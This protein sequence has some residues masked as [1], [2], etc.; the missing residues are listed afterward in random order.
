[1][2]SSTPPVISLQ[3]LP[4]LREKTEDVAQVL[5]QQLASHLE[6]LRPLYAPER[7]FGK[8]TGG[9]LDAPTSELALSG[10]KE[11]YTP[12]AGKPVNL[13]ADFDT[14]WLSLTGTSV[15]LLPW[16]YTHMVGDKEVA[17]TNPAR[18]VL[19][20]KTGFSIGKL[21]AALNGKEVA[22]PEVLRQ[23]IVNALVL[24]SVLRLAPGLTQLL[25]DLRYEVKTE[26]L[27]EFRSVP[28]VVVSSCL[29]TFRPPDEM[30]SMAMAFSGVA[31]FVELLDIEASKN[32]RDLLKEKIAELLG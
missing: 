11:K 31:A 24:Q 4:G 8:Y 26:V 1:M 22:R 14:Q 6:T 9:K 21:R 28:L 3:D 10:L 18:W 12:F 23:F 7:F 16:E 27:P 17:M 32:P 25:T 2:S 29:H 30:I 13:S 5:R 15:E 20:Y 19:N